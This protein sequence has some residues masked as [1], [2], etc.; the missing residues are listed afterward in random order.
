M[1]QL[2]EGI[3]YQT[4]TPRYGG[5]VPHN[6]SVALLPKARIWSSICITLCQSPQYDSVNF[7]CE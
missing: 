5:P 1:N 3:L 2:W 6:L 7:L 4:Q